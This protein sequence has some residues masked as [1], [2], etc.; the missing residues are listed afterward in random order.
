MDPAL[1]LSTSVAFHYDDDDDGDQ[2]DMKEDEKY[3]DSRR[4]GE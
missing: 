3:E 1:V 4:V 2:E